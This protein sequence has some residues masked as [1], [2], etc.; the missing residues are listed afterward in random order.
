M[1][2]ITKDNLSSFIEYYHGFHDS[3]ISNINYD[4]KRS[5]IEL[6]I[7]VHWSDTPSLKKDGT[8]ETNNIKMRMIF[9]GVEHCNFKELFSWDYIDD[10]F[11][12][13]III[14]NKEYICFASSEEEPFVYIVCDSIEYEEF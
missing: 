6:F 4:I 8:F 13:Y 12:N 1:T 7:D 9:K 10:V 14:K 5:Q 2:E 11:I 3:F